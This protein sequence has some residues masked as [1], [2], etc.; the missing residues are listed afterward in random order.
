MKTIDSFVD[1]F[2]KFVMACSS[3]ILSVVTFIQVIT[4]F[5]YKNPIAWGQDIIR[6][7]FIYLVFWGGA[8][9]IKEKEHLNID[10]LLTSVSIKTRKIME[11]VINLI[12]A[13]FFIFIV[14]Y[15]FIFMKSGAS[16]KAPYLPI[17][18]SLYYLALPS[19][20]LLMLYYQIQIIFQQIKDFKKTSSEVEVRV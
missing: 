13:L 10:I 2:L 19:S 17:P 15:G 11:I 20:V 9:C 4:R 5:I 7:S 6:L 3:L 1:G 18:M 8:Y 16:Q 12:L 14:Y